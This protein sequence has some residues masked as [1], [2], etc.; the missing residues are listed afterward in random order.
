M[1]ARTI[2]PANSSGRTEEVE[3][4]GVVGKQPVIR[5]GEAHEYNSYCV[6]STFEGVMEGTYQ[7][8]RPNGEIFYVVV[9]RF[10]LR[11]ASN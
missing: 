1:A 7:M 10:T 6:L 9:P 5:P 4:E 8:V 2:T 3:G 11:A